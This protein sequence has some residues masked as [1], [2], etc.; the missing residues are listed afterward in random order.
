MPT[1]LLESHPHFCFH[2]P[3][4]NIHQHPDLHLCN[5]DFEGECAAAVHHDAA[6]KANLI[7]EAGAVNCP[8]CG[9]ST[10]FKSGEKIAEVHAKLCTDETIH[11]PEMF[12]AGTLDGAQY[13]AWRATLTRDEQ[14]GYYKRVPDIHVMARLTHEE[15][16]LMDTDLPA[17]NALLQQRLKERAETALLHQAPHRHT[18]TRFPISV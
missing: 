12:K 8:K 4:C 9:G 13:A 1:S 15:T 10:T 14:L 7:D 6:E 17:F 11:Y 5:D 16:A 2:S 18:T 3:V